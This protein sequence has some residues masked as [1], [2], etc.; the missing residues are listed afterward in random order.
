MEAYD[1]D[2]PNRNAPQGIVYSIVKEEQRKLLS[3]DESGCLRLIK[4]CINKILIIKIL[5]YY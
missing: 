4:V 3:I 2:I 1:P 5:L